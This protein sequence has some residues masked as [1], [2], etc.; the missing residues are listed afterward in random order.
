M[1]KAPS[2]FS[3]IQ[4]SSKYITSEKDSRLFHWKQAAESCSR[5]LLQNQVEDFLCE[6]NDQTAE[7]GQKAGAALR[8]VVG[9]QAQTDLHHAPAQQ[10]HADGFDGG[11]DKGGQVV[12]SGQRIFTGGESGR[13]DGAGQHAGQHSAEVAPFCLARPIGGVQNGFLLH[14]EFPPVFQD[15]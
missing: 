12:D 15:F 13:A 1:A 2:K 10:N 5:S 3:T 9:L 14:F 4:L 8:R 11:K 7:K 6:R